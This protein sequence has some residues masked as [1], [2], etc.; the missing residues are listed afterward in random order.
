MLSGKKRRKQ[1]KGVDPIKGGFVRAPKRGT[2]SEQLTEM[3]QKAEKYGKK[4][5][6]KEAKKARQLE[7][8]P[9][10]NVRKKR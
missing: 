7:Y 1:N 9:K 5:A 2:G 10:R 8:I 4:V 6:K 3:E